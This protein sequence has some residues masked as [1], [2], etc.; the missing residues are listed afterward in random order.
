MKYILKVQNLH[1]SYGKIKAVDGIDF[2]IKEG[3]CFGL[4]G[5][6]GA[7]KST[8]IEIL[9]GILKENSG[10][11]LYKDKKRKKNFKKDIGVVFQH[12]SLAEFLSVQD[13][14]ELFAGLYK[15]SVNL[16]KLIKRCQLQD[17]LKQDANKLS[18]G[19]KQRL[20]F[21]I[22][23]INDPQILILDEPT[24]G[25]DPVS[26]RSFWELIK[27]QKKKNKTIILTTHYMEEAQTLCDEIAIISNGKIISQGE[28]NGLLKEYFHSTIL[29]IPAKDVPK[30]NSF[31]FIYQ[32]DKA[33]LST[34]NIKKSLTDLTKANISL[35][36]LSIHK[37]SLED[38]F[39][40]LTHKN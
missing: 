31:D 37:A 16:D 11:I 7:G 4:L 38:L 8:T 15:D 14:L 13:Q 20:L 9:E 18:G 10:N 27:K 36:E 3:S 22:A 25:L 39:I 34:T 23:L 12:T 28:P 2:A 33:Q 21:A 26:R 5:P 40:L 24:T 35:E 29:E 30:N 17:I 19:Q 1:K 6:N 32:G